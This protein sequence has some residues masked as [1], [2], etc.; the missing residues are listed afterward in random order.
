[1][2][3]LETNI[4][5]DMHVVAL[6]HFAIAIGLRAVV[7]DYI[8]ALVHIGALPLRGRWR[9]SVP[10]WVLLVHG[11]WGRHRRCVFCKSRFW[12]WKRP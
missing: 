3:L 7:G 4:S 10:P 9:P 5:P 1:M 11:W 6:H 12:G 8:C 2:H